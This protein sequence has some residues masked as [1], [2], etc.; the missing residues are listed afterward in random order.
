MS[1]LWMIERDVVDWTDEDVAAAGIR[2]K[3]CVLW[4]PNMEWQRSFFDR[5]G[6]RLLC[7]YQAETEEDVRQ[8]SEAA[9]LPCGTVIP[10]DEVLPGDLDEPTEGDLASLPSVRVPDLA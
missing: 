3:M 6:D 10:I 8:H 1:K 5:D 2:A 9:G 4:Y 7:I